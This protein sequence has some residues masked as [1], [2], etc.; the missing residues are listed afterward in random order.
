MFTKIVS[1]IYNFCLLL[2]GNRL[3]YHN[4]DQNNV[5][6]EI[7]FDTVIIRSLIATNDAKTFRTKNGSKKSG[8]SVGKLNRPGLD[9]ISKGIVRMF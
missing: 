3:M 5:K 9:R 8:K 6:F 4:F 7:V 1:N 2:G